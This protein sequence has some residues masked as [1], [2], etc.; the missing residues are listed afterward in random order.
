LSSQATALQNRLVPPPDFNI[1]SCT[2]INSSG[3]CNVVANLT[4]GIT[5]I[6]INADNVT[7]NLNGHTITGPSAGQPFR[8]QHGPEQ[9]W[10]GSGG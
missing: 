7:L 3:T 1:S 9:R 10:R 4:S 2:A 8:S 6:T 5:C